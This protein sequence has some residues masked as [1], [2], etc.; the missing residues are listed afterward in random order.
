MVQTLS[1]FFLFFSFSFFFFFLFWGGGIHEVRKG[2]W[3][4]LLYFRGAG[5]WTSKL[6]SYGKSIRNVTRLSAMNSLWCE[7]HMDQS[8]QTYYHQH[9]IMVSLLC[10]KKVLYQSLMLKIVHSTLRIC[11]WEGVLTQSHPMILVNSKFPCY[12]QRTMKLSHLCTNQSPRKTANKFSWYLF[13]HLF[14]WLR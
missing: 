12:W 8:W 13:I 14:V 3:A 11:C 2:K 5:G 9:I 4:F 7:K 10:T 1:S 6:W